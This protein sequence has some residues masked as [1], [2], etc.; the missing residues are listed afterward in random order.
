MRL[1]LTGQNR[2][3][4]EAVC[5]DA[6][7]KCS[8]LRALSLFPVTSTRTATEHTHFACTRSRSDS[9]CYGLVSSVLRWTSH[10]KCTY[11]EL[12]LQLCVQFLQLFQRLLCITMSCTLNA[13]LMSVILLQV[14]NVLVQVL[15]QTHAYICIILP[16][17]RVSL[18]VHGHTVPQK[19]MWTTEH[20]TIK[21]L[22]CFLIFNFTFPTSLYFLVLFPFFNS[23]FLAVCITSCRVLE[24][25]DRMHSKKAWAWMQDSKLQTPKCRTVQCTNYRCYPKRVRS[26][27]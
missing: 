7:H 6:L 4:D 26:Q 16:A 13:Y 5:S 24:I 14:F 11:L 12:N 20:G 9:K 27:C 8:A 17:K 3:D 23:L 21:N 25:Q 2:P 18:Y 15:R 1:A 19:I 10:C 22:L